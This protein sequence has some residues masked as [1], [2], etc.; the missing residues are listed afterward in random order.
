MAALSYERCLQSLQS[1][2][3]QTISLC[4]ESLVIQPPLDFQF[5]PTD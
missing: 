2:Y 5:V 4:G 3:H 1:A